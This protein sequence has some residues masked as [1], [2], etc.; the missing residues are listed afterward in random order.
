MAGTHIQAHST[1]GRCI[2]RALINRWGRMKLQ[3]EGEWV[4]VALSNRRVQQV[5][6]QV[7]HFLHLHLKNETNI[8]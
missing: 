2:N 3:I 1:D 5:C 8:H 4:E 6:M 7:E